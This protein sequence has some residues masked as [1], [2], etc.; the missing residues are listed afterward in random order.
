M[1]LPNNIIR[2]ISIAAAL[3]HLGGIACENQS[4]ATTTN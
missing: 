2:S 1:L 4:V 3:V